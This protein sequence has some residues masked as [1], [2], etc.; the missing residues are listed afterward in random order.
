[1]TSVHVPPPVTW[2]GV[3][4]PPVRPDLDASG[5][6]VQQSAWPST[7]RV[8][9]VAALIVAILAFGIFGVTPDGNGIAQPIDSAL[10]ATIDLHTARPTLL[11]RAL[12]S[13]LLPALASVAVALLSRTRG[14]LWHRLRPIIV[15]AATGIVTWSIAT[16]VARPAP[17]HLG[18]LA[19]ASATSFPPVAAAMSAAL[20]YTVARSKAPARTR[21]RDVRSVGIAAAAAVAV[22]APGLLTATIWPLDVI[23]GVAVGVAIAHLGDERQATP[24]HARRTGPQR[25]RWVALMSAAVLLV[26]ASLSYAQI[27]AARGNA[28]VDQRTIEWLRDHG[29]GAFV[30]RG[31]SWWLWRHLPSTTATISELPAAPVSPQLATIVRSDLP[32]NVR[33]PIQPALSDEG[34]WSVAAADAQGVPELATTYFRPDRAHPSVVVGVAWVN[35][36]N[37]KI[38]LIAGTRQPGGGVGAAGGRVP[39]S[40]RDALLAAFNSGYKMKDTPG[41]ALVEGHL[42]NHLVAG[43]ATLAVLPDGTATVGAWGTDLDPHR[44]YLAIRQNL[45]LM[46][47]DGSPVAGVATNAGGRWGTVKNALP[48]WRSGLGV[49]AKG[50]LVYVAGHSLTLGALAHALIDAGA[51]TAMELDIHRGMVTFNLFTHDSQGVVGHKLLPDMTR[52]ADRYLTTDWRDFVMV[53]SR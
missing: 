19:A 13:P 47:V 3:S 25:M 48:T 9:A 33:A 14:G 45:Q 40:A 31:E 4:S 17:G 44:H 43:L 38:S 6:P 15:T 22:T 32:S 28:P 34:K 27:L 8:F 7:A 18:D 53:T 52:S 11:L 50:D 36:A 10:S 2:G 20:A 16:I 5:D 26:P 46:V 12:S 1:V 42:T 49:T 37:T 23:A 41:G 21:R 29:L 35:S 51:V 39:V 24:H 30:D